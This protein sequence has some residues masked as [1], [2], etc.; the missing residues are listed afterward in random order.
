MKLNTGAG[1]QVKVLGSFLDKIKLKG[2]RKI[3]PCTTSF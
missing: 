2:V 3:L 1:L